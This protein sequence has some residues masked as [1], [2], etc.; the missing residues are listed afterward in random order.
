MVLFSNEKKIDVFIVA[1]VVAKCGIVVKIAEGKS[2]GFFHNCTFFFQLKTKIPIEELQSVGAFF[3]YFGW[4]L[5]LAKKSFSVAG[6]IRGS[7]G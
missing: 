5:V 1:V 3:P 6:K 4:L 2:V 7:D